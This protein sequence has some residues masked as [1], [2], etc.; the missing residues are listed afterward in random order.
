ML[1]RRPAPTLV[2]TAIAA[3]V[4]ILPWAI[5]G[6]PGSEHRD[7][8]SAADTV[9]SQQPLTGLGGG[10]TIR[11]IS[12]P[13]PF[14]MVA[15]T[16]T[17][18][19]GT[20]AR[21]RAKKADGSW[22]PWYNADTLE[23]NADDTQGGGP[24]GTDPVFV[25][26]TTSVQIAVTRPPNAP[27]TSAPPETGLDAGKEL[28]YVPATAEQPFAQNI[29]AVLITPPKAPVDS[30]WNPPTAALGPGQ[31]PNIISRSQWGADEHMRCGNTVYGPGIRAAV[32]HHT[33]GSNDYAP[34]DSAAIVRSIYAYHTRTLGWCDIAYNALVDKYGQVF[35]GRA[36]GITKDVLGSHTGGFNRDVWGVSM[37][38]DFEDVP[39][40][41]IL[42]R[43]VGRLLG[44]RL[45]L[46]R[47]NPLGT[48]TLTSA[49]SEYT[50]FPAGATPTLPTIFAHRDVGNT[51][52]P[53]NAGYAALGQIRDIAARFNRPPDLIE[54]LRGGAI[55]AKW[56][57]MGGKDGPLG[58]PTSPE[59]SA[60]GDARYVTFE[61]GAIY[62]SPNTEAQPLTGA[63]YEAWASLGYERGALGLPTSGEIQEPE[64]IVQ[65]F[66]HGTL[67]FDR[68][69]HNVLRVVDALTL[70][71]P[72]PPADGPPVQLERFTRATN[73]APEPVS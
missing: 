19:T 25:G 45:G 43:T 31:P 3:T 55:F 26:N 64:W 7:G 50:F 65:N 52:C 18:L 21:V 37:I 30:Q 54:S 44:W 22:G 51:A 10:M 38:G 2:F 63:I 9:L 35:E 28:G 39:P 46:D 58:M 29:S 1:P 4:V 68:Q 61:H 17:D 20:S 53:G 57:A 69:T 60:D 73:P 6:V 40:T 56:E 13:T 62:W 49:G 72:P 16:G 11:E 70:V 67:N 27:I 8:S 12:Q 34:E 36:G 32:V 48:V 15:L 33:A 5:T 24:R 41:D 66:Q 23:S 59:A 14:S 42:I 71:M 47:V